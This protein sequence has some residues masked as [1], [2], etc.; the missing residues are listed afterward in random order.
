VTVDP[1]IEAGVMSII[2]EDVEFQPTVSDPTRVYAPPLHAPSPPRRRSYRRAIAAA[3]AVT[4]VAIGGIGAATLPAGSPGHL[5]LASLVSQ[6]Q[7]SSIEQVIQTANSEQA[8][9]LATNDP[10]AMSDTATASYYRQLVQTNQ[11][12]AAQGVTSIKLSNLTWGP[13]SVNGSSASATTSETWVTTFNDGT[14]SESTDTNV[15]MLVQQNGVWL[16]ESDQQPTQAPTAA[17]PPSQTQPSAPSPAATSGA[18]SHNW[19]GYAAT[20]GTYTAVS[21][22]WTVPQPSAANSTGGVGATWVGIG[23]VTSQ[24]LIQA[25]TQDVTVGSQHQF[26]SWIETLPQASQQ[27]PL[28]VAPGDSVSVAITESAPGSGVWSIDMTNNTNGQSYQT[29]VHYTSSESSAEWI[30]EAPA[31]QSGNTTVIAPLD[32]F[33]T[34]SFSGAAATKNGETVDLAQAGARAIT[35]LNSASQPLAVP[36]DVASN[37]SSFTVTRT[38]AV[39]TTTPIGRAR[40]R[41]RGTP[42]VSGR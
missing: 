35:L 38:S 32:S 9:A 4:L 42:P 34:V 1:V 40:Q 19:S 2:Q 16:I 11:Q 13:I 37:G 23:G 20:S 17:A 27:V 3:I 15:Y 14:T 5:Y 8:E 7:T 6:S 24:D 33:G 22:T 31:D 28:A 21:G 30:E 41:G 10:S 25:G 39:A 12:M 36:S 18:T 26:Q 29:T